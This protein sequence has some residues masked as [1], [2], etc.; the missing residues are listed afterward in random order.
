MNLYWSVHST[1]K[2]ISHCSIHL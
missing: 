2:I 1:F